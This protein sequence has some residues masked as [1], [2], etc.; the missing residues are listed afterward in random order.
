LQVYDQNLGDNSWLVVWT[1]NFMTFHI[2]GMSSSQ[3]D[4]LHHF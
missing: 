2:L 1:M 4:E 3:S